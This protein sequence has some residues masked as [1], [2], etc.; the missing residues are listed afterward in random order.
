[1]AV[2]GLTPEEEAEFA[3]MGAAPL[4]AGGDP[5]PDDQ[6]EAGPAEGDG[7]PAPAAQP[8]EGQPRDPSGKFAP[9]PEGQPAA[10]APAEGEPNPA[11]Q[12]PQGFVPHA[13]LHAERLE[14]ARTA[15]QLQMLSN[16]MN[17]LLE[18]QQSNQQTEAPPSMTED[19]VAYLTWL[20]ER[21]EQVSSG[22]REQ[23]EFRQID[24]SINQDE[25]LFKMQV[26]DYDQASEH[27]V[28]SR[29]QELSHF[30]PPA[31]V[32][33]MLMQ[34]VRQMA[35]MARQRGTSVAQMIY[36]SAQARGYRSAGQMQPAPTPQPIP[37]Q[38]S[39]A[40]APATPQAQP[41][42]NGGQQRLQSIR[43]GVQ[44]SRSLG[45]GGAAPATQLNADAILNMSDEEFE[46][47]LGL[48]TKGADDR[49]RA[50]FGG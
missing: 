1:M 28:A 32:Q 16:R 4:G 46:A 43:Q 34:E 10:P 29:A 24:A 9:K 35:Q 37:Q 5:I 36:G 27:Y 15:Q 17:M 45:T 50:L 20:Q 26:P 25:E 33:T 21:V 39:A 6:M 47:S 30:Y 40:P 23:Q 8:G 48:G 2:E 44:A 41:Q 3:A 42:A 11:A 14:R 22:V 7:Q 12:A 49:F 13:A 38:Q 19:P 18:R 31:E